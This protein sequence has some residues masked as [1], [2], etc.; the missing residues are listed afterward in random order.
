MRWLS[1]S[2]I[3]HKKG[4]DIMRAILPKIPGAWID[5]EEDDGQSSST[6]AETSWAYDPAK[7]TPILNL[8]PELRLQILLIII[9]E[10]FYDTFDRVCLLIEDIKR[11]L[12]KRPPAYILS[13]LLINR[14]FHDE[15]E[16]ALWKNFPLVI[17]SYWLE[18]SDLPRA[19][20][21]LLQ[22]SSYACSNLLR[23]EIPLHLNADN[24][25]GYDLPPYQNCGLFQVKRLAARLTSLLEVT[26]LIIVDDKD[27]MPIPTA[28][29]S[30]IEQ[31]C[32][33][34]EDVV[35]RFSA[36]KVVFAIEEDMKDWISSFV[37]I[38]QGQD[39]IGSVTFEIRNLHFWTLDGMDERTR[40]EQP[41]LALTGD[42]DPR[43]FPRGRSRRCWFW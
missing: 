31:T 14:V 8:P 12:C 1:G 35:T 11:P 33:V 43:N 23:L 41:T 13:L 37:R 40:A 22:L 19:V 10:A 20:R 15:A 17:H 42:G 26:F 36:E 25:W 5:E 21:P 24:L 28:K 9:S 38:F 39:H 18:T 30:D 3:E 16:T 34:L 29:R 6:S 7:P 27:L 4:T 2:R 32:S